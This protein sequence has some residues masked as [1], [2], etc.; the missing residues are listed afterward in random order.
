[1]ILDSLV[2]KVTTEI[3]EKR[4]TIIEERIKLIL[5]PKPKWMSKSVWYWLISK[6]IYISEERP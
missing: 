6:L 2:F 5:K 4:A 3:G 1:M